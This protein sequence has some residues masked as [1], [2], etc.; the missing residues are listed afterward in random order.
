MTQ[1]VEE[2][3]LQDVVRVAGREAAC[4]AGTAGREREGRAAAPGEAAEAAPAA[5]E[6]AEAAAAAAAWWRAVLEPL[7][8]ELVVDGALVRVG[9]DL[10]GF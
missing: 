4:A 10:E 1:L 8:A 3:I 6:A 7:L 5:R 2:C 9:E